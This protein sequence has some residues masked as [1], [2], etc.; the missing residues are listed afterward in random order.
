MQIDGDAAEEGTTTHNHP[1]TPK[2]GLERRRGVNTTTLKHNLN[3]DS[4][5]TSQTQQRTINHK[6]NDEL[7]REGIE[8]ERESREP[9]T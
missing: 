2:H 4:T 7:L 5:Q 3:G 6:S 8:R 9:V 1:K